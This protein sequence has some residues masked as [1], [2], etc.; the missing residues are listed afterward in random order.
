MTQFQKTQT[1]DPE[2]LERKSIIFDLLVSLF[3]RAF[4]LVYEE[5]MSD[6]HRRLWASWEDYIRFWC[7]REDFRQALPGLIAGEDPDF[8]QY[9]MGIARQ[10]D[11][12]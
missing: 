10:V 9:I 1:T 8:E 4:I 7:A 11:I 5:D 3:E 2:K 12:Q 6:Q